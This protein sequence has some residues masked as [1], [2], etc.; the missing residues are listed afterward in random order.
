MKV[1]HEYNGTLMDSTEEVYFA[2]WLD[3]A[4]KAGWVEKWKYVTEPFQICRAVKGPY[5]KT[6]VLKT[7][8][9]TEYK[10]FTIL[11][12]LEYTPDFKIKWT[13]KGMDR[14]VSVL[15]GKNIEDYNQH[16]YINPKSIFFCGYWQ[17]K[18]ISLSTTTWVEVKPTF[19]MHGKIS[20]FSV[21]QKILW[22][23]K[24]LF[25]D[26]IQFPDLFKETWMPEAIMDDFR[27]KV[28]PKKAAAKGKKKGDFKMDWKVRSL[29]EFLKDG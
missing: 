14:F 29:K 21:L 9:K 1:I 6:T 28:V 26:L 7:K 11:Q 10:V 3:D 25:V 17:V 12:D 13:Q 19:D 5:L 2:H 24:G 22:T 8:V 23:F 4:I 16:E 27:Y 18:D 15:Q 20:K